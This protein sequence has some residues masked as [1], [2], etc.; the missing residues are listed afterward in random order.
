MVE[1]G[2]GPALCTSHGVD[3]FAGRRPWSKWYAEAYCDMDP[4]AK[5]EGTNITISRTA[6]S[7]I[8]KGR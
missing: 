6:D 2:R 4:S 7:G 3:N 8:E 1:K 5:Y